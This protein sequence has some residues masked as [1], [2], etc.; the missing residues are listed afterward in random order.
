MS[1]QRR[2]R[3]KIRLVEQERINAQSEQE[4]VDRILDKISSQGM[5]SLTRKELKILHKASE[6]KK[7]K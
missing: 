3:R 4:E 5:E 1:S 6:R 2:R 7:Q